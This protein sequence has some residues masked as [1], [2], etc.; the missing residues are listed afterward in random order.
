MG[1]LKPTSKVKVEQYLLT[2]GEEGASMIDIARGAGVSLSMARVSLVALE[3]EGRARRKSGHRVVP[4][5]WWPKAKQGAKPEYSVHRALGDGGWE[6]LRRSTG[7]EPVFTNVATYEL[8]A[9]AVEVAHTLNGWAG[10]EL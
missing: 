7:E 9:A 6:V 1:G 8:E 5:I 3:G 4:D 2:I 10:R